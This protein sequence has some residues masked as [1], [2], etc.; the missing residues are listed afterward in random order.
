MSGLRSKLIEELEER[1]SSGIRQNELDSIL[2]YSRS[3]ISETV[4]ALE[5]DGLIIRKKEGKSANRIW[6]SEHFPSHIEGVLRVG[7]LRSSEYVPFL[8]FLHEGFSERFKIVVCVHDDASELISSLHTGT[9]DIAM[10]P[11]FT[12]ILYSMTARKEMIVSTVSYGGSSLLRNTSSD[13]GI[14]ATSESS[15]MALMSREIVKEG[16]ATVHF[17]TDPGTAA[18]EFL[19]GKFSFIAIWEPYL[20]FLKSEAN[21]EEITNE[22]GNNFLSPCCSVGVNREFADSDK[23]FALSLGIGYR[24]FLSRADPEKM[25]FGTAIISDATGFSKQEIL[26]SLKS[27]KF[28]SGIDA[29]TLSTY[30]IN[31]GLP[32][33]ASKL[34]E[35]IID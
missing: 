14:L 22:T 15:T 35:M 29:D 5:E 27:Y 28:K 16:K 17:F 23:E 3:H 34:R 33:S 18:K 7:I 11:T 10:A 24:K 20:S 1:K 8:S 6:L 30:M 9:L 19:A 31:V 32:M 12:H 4:S 2:G 13:S 21:V 26:Q 25:E